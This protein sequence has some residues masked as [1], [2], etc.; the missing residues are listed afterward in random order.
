MEQLKIQEKKGANYALLELVGSIDSYNFTEFQQKAFSLIRSTN[1]VL[2][3]SEVISMDSSGLSVI[4]GA[5]TTGEDAGN[6]LY[7]MRP[8]TGAHKAIES[9]GF[10]DTFH[11]IQTVTEVL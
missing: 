3:L 1:L 8:S 10:I 7:I 11:I 4:L 5:Y 6:T 2:D 9:T